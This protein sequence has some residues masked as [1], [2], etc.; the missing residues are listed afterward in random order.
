MGQIIISFSQQRR[1]LAIVRIVLQFLLPR[2]LADANGLC[3]RREP[4]CL[5][6]QLN[7][8]GWC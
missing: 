1:A 8:I 2:L 4:R 3:R 7:N 6:V 5:F